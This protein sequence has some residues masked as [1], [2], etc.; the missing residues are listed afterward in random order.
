MSVFIAP[1]SDQTARTAPTTIM[2]VPP[3]DW[4][5]TFVR[6]RSSSAITLPGTI[7]VRWDSRRWARPASPTVANTPTATS[8][9]D[10]IARNRL[11]ATA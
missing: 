5:V 6:L 1:V 8:A 9:A 4:C 3:F 2:I 11:K 10:G 7:P